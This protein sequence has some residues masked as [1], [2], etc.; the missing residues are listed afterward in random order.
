MQAEQ[1]QPAESLVS[2]P[3]PSRDWPPSAPR[4]LLGALIGSALGFAV[5]QTLYPIYVVPPE[6]ANLPDPPPTAAV[7]KLEA[8]LRAVDL[9]NFSIVFSAIGLLLGASYALCAFGLRCPRRLI[10]TSVLGAVSC[11]AGALICNSIISKMRSSGGDDMLLFGFTLDILKQTILSQACLWG[12]TGLG[13]GIGLA[14][15][16]KAALTAGIS[17][18]VGGMLSAMLYVVGV[19]FFLPI[20]GGYHAFPVTPT[21]Q[22]AWLAFNACTIG[23]TIALGTGERARKADSERSVPAGVTSTAT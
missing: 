23:L 3:S 17:G 19:A 20:V 22:I 7:E 16:I 9:K 8:A 18:L 10:M 1:S 4:L 2:A 12:L 21:Q 13:I 6:L 5:L 11:V 15:S 14:P